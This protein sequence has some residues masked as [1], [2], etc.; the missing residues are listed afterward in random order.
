MQHMPMSN[1]LRVIRGHINEKQYLEAELI[2]KKVKL[3]NVR[4]NRDNRIQGIFINDTM[5]ESLR[6]EEVLRV[7]KISG[8][9]L[10]EFY[11][12]ALILED[13]F[14]YPTAVV[15]GVLV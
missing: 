6:N 4:T 7:D 11:D 10:S 9:N 5:A 3:R 15:Q 14:Y 1:Q 8:Y 12:V 13:G 2:G